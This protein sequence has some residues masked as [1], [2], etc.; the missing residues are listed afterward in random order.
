M[1]NSDWARRVTRGMEQEASYGGAFGLG[2]NTVDW[3]SPELGYWSDCPACGG[4]QRSVTGECPDCSEWV[5]G[6]DPSAHGAVPPLGSEQEKDR[7]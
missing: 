5:E 1:A 7:G 3:A 4:D 6:R 2:A